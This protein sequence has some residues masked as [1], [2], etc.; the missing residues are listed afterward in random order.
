MEARLDLSSLFIDCETDFDRVMQEGKTFKERCIE[1]GCEFWDRNFGGMIKK[2]LQLVVAPTNH[3]KTSFLMALA[4]S[5]CARGHKGLY[6]CT[7]EDVVD[8][9][10]EIGHPIP[11]LT[12]VNQPDAT[13]GIKLVDLLAIKPD[14]EFVCLDYFGSMVAETLGDAHLQQFQVMMQYME[15][16]T[17]Y[18]KDNN[19]AIVAGMQAKYS[20]LTDKAFAVRQAGL[21]GPDNN[22]YV[23]LA[24]G[25]GQKPTGCVYLTHD[26]RT[27]KALINIFKNR[28][29]HWTPI[30]EEV[31]LD[32]A[33]K[34]FLGSQPLFSNSGV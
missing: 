23:S 21:Y 5:T 19:I 1:T 33:T 10:R 4:Q 8:L 12:M 3:G 18:C 29:G 27:D 6:V 34:T 9:L 31:R 28:H 16:L 17:N 2:E 13:T 22:A 7:E 24:T 20:L 30:I 15:E 11:N 32:Y 26:T 25:V 14:I